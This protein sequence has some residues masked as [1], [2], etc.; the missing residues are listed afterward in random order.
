MASDK[1]EVLPLK[2]VTDKVSQ[3]NAKDDEPLK[4]VAYEQAE[5]PVDDMLEDDAFFASD[6]EEADDDIPVIE[7]EA[8]VFDSNADDT[9][10]IETSEDFVSEPVVVDEGA[11]PPMR[12]A[13]IDYADNRMDS[14]FSSK[15]KWFILVIVA[16]AAIVIGIIA[17]AAYNVVT[18]VPEQ[19]EPN[20]KVYDDSN[21]VVLESST[22]EDISTIK[23]SVNVE[24]VSSVSV[25]DKGVVSEV[26]VKEGNT[27]KKGDVLFVLT[28]DD[29]NAQLDSAQ[30]VLDDVK[31]KRDEAKALVDSQ[32]AS[33]G[34]A[35]D[36]VTSAQST[37]D[38]LQ[39][40]AS[41]QNTTETTNE[42]EEK[43]ESAGMNMGSSKLSQ[44]PIVRTITV[45]T[46]PDSVID[47]AESSLT[48]AETSL[49]RAREAYDEADAQLQSEQALVDEAQ[50]AFDDIKS[51]ID[52]LTVKASANGTVTLVNIKKGQAAPDDFKEGDKVVEISN[53]SVATI[54]INVTG[55][56]ADGFDKN[57]EV[58]VFMHDKQMKATL[59]DVGVDGDTTTA[60][61][62]LND[63]G[64]DVRD[65]DECTV[66]LVKDVMPNTFVVPDSALKRKGDGPAQMVLVHDEKNSESISVTIVGRVDDTHSAVRSMLL[67]EGITV[68]TDLS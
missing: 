44:E 11:L 28:D 66:E 25:P 6:E 34:A 21:T 18:Y 8:D 12:P 59:S 58:R 31:A 39:R 4:K 22:Y 49:E 61:I 2:K 5:E 57:D 46:V 36:A 41:E 3:P 65:G 42:P 43:E 64:T 62:T 47:A 54:N 17:V 48:Y 60:K 35:Q 20:V 68:A 63:V 14:V 27:V 1:T 24:K 33:L 67:K 19:R 26:K 32:S 37:L 38:T 15:N 9:V 23:T 55:E 53:T 30:K 29:L 52:A 45:E 10:P 7:D 51:Q 13:S 56:D 50:S 16:I 40:V